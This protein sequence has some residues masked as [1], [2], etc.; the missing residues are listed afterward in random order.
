MTQTLHDSIHTSDITQALKTLYFNQFHYIDVSVYIVE[1]LVPSY[2]PFSCNAKRS[3]NVTQ[4]FA[5]EDA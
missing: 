5:L 1:L 2:A 4:E 3:I